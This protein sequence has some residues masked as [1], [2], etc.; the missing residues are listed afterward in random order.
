MPELPFSANQMFN[1]KRET[2][3]ERIME[4]YQETQNSTMTIKLL[5]TLR[6]RYQLGSEEFALV[7]KELVHYLFTRTR[8]TR[9]MKRFFYYFQDYFDAPKWQK[10]RL[11]VFPV[12]N[13]IEK[14]KSIVQSALAK[15]MP[16]EAT[17]T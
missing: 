8:A 13:F 15:F 10:L 1:L 7:L 4:Y 16:T 2:L 14:A 9:T 12:R 6:V 17:A 11:R 3:E 5:L